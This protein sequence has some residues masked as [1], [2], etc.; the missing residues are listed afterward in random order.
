MDCNL[1]SSWLCYCCSQPHSCHVGNF[2]YMSNF[3]NPSFPGLSLP[4]YTGVKIYNAS[5]G[6]KGEHLK[7]ICQH[8]VHTWSW[9]NIG[10]CHYV[11]AAIES[12]GWRSG[13]WREANVV[14]MSTS[15]GRWPQA[16]GTSGRFRL[17]VRK[18]FSEREMMQWHGLPREVVGSPSLEVFKNCCGT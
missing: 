11:L 8:N 6:P 1:F 16:L 10:W 5:T 14:D 13:R 3:D 9:Q 15:L 7:Q 12:G 17:D 2:A 18:N 4:I